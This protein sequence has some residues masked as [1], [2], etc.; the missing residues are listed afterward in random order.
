M[1]KY[2]GKNKNIFF[3]YYPDICLQPKHRNNPFEFLYSLTRKSINY[4]VF[5]LTR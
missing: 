4:S 2:Q 3:I 5:L 1:R